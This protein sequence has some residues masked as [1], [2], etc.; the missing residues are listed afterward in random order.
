MRLIM[1]YDKIS[2]FAQT[3][4]ADLSTVSALRRDPFL[5][6]CIDPNRAPLPVPVVGGGDW[7]VVFGAGAA[8][9]GGGG[10]GAGAVGLFAAKHIVK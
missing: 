7:G 4:G 9:G 3:L 5:K 1:N 8:G 2:R 10:G 6:P